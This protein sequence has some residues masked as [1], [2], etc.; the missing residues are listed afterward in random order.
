[1]NSIWVP[2]L[3]QRWSLHDVGD[4]EAL[5]IRAVSRSRYA[6]GLRPDERDDLVTYLF[7][8]AW[9]LSQKFD[10]ER[11]S[12]A[13]FLY[14]AAQRR[15]IDWHRSRYRTRWAFKDRVY[16]RKL[17]EFVSLDH[18]DDGGQLGGTVDEGSGA[19]APGWDSGLGGILREA[20]RHR[21][22]DIEILGLRSARR[23]AG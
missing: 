22:A 20:D 23:A 16:E 19:H 14:G 15:I 18:G 13:V 21:A 9:K 3:T 5:L 6:D 11:G 8:F 1:M 17:P 2:L 7:E 10:P 4:V 12:F